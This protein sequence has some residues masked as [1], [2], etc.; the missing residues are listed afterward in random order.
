M[1]HLSTNVKCICKRF[2]S[3]LAITVLV[4]ARATLGQSPVE[5]RELVPG[6]TVEREMTSAETH[7]YKFDLQANEFFQVR[8]EQKDVDVVLKLTDARGKL[9]ATMDSP[10]G[11]EGP[12]TLSFVAEKPGNFLLE[13][14]GLDAKAAKGGYAIK[15]SI[16][17][18][19]TGN[20]RRRVEVEQAFVEGLAARNTEGQK[21]LAAN[22]LRK[23]LTGWNELEDS[24]LSQLTDQQLKQLAPVPPEISVIIDSIKKEHQ[25]AMNLLGEGQKLSAKSSADSLPAREKLVR[26]LTDFRSVNRSARDKNTLDTISRSG[27]SASQ[28]L[29]TLKILE[30][31]SRIGEAISLSGISQTHTNLGERQQAIDATKEA[32][33]VY[34]ELFADPTLLSITG[35]DVK[36]TIPT[37]KSFHAASL[38]SIGH[39]L[40]QFLGESEQGIA[41]LTQAA[42]G[43]H[44]LFQE[45]GDTQFRVLEATALSQIGFIY[46]R[47]SKTN[48]KAIE[49]LTNGLTVYES[50]P[51]ERRSV[52]ST[53]N[54]LGIQHLL[55]YD[56]KHASQNWENA[57]AIYRE[58]DDKSGQVDVLRQLGLMYSVLN[59]KT[60]ISEFGNQALE[61]LQSSDF[62]A[63]WK[64]KVP[65]NSFGIYNELYDALIEHTKLDSIAFVYRLLEDYQKSLEY[66]ERALAVA[67]SLKDARNTR[68][69]TDAVA[70]AFAKLEKWD[71]AVA[72]YKRALEISRKQGVKEDIA[73]DLK[74][75][76]WALLETGKP[77]EALNYQNEA[78]SI[79]LSVSVDESRAFS[80]SFSDLL[81]EISRSYHDLG[82]NRLAIFY[83]KRAVNATQSERQRLS[84]LDPLS[85][86]G[87]LERKE[88]HY[89]RLA[90]WL[91][92]EGRIIEAEQVL[93]MLKGEEVS[94]YLRRDKSVADKLSLRVDFTVA[95]TKAL[96]SYEEKSRTISSL[97]VEMGK[98]EE[99]KKRGTQFTREQEQRYDEL[100]TKLSESNANFE[101]FL[102]Q[103]AEEFKQIKN[104]VGEVSE[105][106]GLQSDMQEWGGDLV[107]I[108]TLVGEG[109]YRTILITPK[110]RVAGEREIKAVDLDRKIFEFREQVKN[111]KVDPRPL[112]KELYDILIKPIE[113]ELEGAKAKTLL[114]S[115]DGNLRLL[116]LAALWD[117]QQY[118][119]QKYQNVVITL[120]SRTRIGREVSQTPNV[121]GLGVSE[122]QTARDTLGERNLL[123][124]SLPSV[125]F[126][127][128]SIVRSKQSPKGVLPGESLLNAGFTEKAMEVQLAKGY[129]VIHIASHFSL[130]AGDASR[131]FLLLGDG[132]ILT[133][134]D[135]KNNPSLTL[136]G[137]ELLTLS[138]CDTAVGERDSSGKEVDGFAYVAQARGAKAIIATLWPVADVST[139]LLMSEFYRL[140]KV[141]PQMTKAEALQLAQKE[142]IEGKLQRASTTNQERNTQRVNAGSSSQTFAYDP[143]KPYAHPYYWSPFV[144]IGNWR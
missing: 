64:K 18:S 73:D 84:N 48:E 105:D 127:L 66:Y 17:R 103:L 33:E 13:V 76:G 44:S 132:S 120:A 135:L 2:P 57:L 100:E 98:L 53:L 74:D 6:Q 75:V 12:E 108:Y 85:Q 125:P 26:A 42:D 55:N 81:N 97:A 61:I 121:L 128:A 23:A 37:W 143:K 92:A 106:T 24:Y 122:A 114:W 49:F 21:E 99:L 117:G 87:F 52:A 115:L 80:V 129:K 8:V 141:N 56:F 5:I 111:P 46:A 130:N 20:D 89:R 137:V 31:Q 96:K 22:K 27:E 118:F 86:K 116:P 91:I 144:L 82:N 88:K 11:K 29:N 83:A 133:V 15:R 60:K 78:L 34:K 45:T 28:S 39:D 25:E 1:S 14:S 38:A 4:V 16:S 65:G 47:E 134:N 107:F 63:S 142:M 43:Y 54:S 119:G 102:D 19:A 72:S 136:A 67:P 68:L 51:D 79:Y 138:A 30:F 35:I 70:R 110:A 126:E 101:K 112:G 9:L 59:D 131:S 123:F 77:S 3:L 50:L 69:S 41:Y 36:K 71:N 32:A 7:H 58:L 40:D 94:D 139:S 93:R 104:P 140:R 109:R 124:S 62:A 95:E 10:N 113:K 90:D